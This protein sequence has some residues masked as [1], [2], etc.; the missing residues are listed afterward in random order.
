MNHPWTPL[1]PGDEIAVVAP[2]MAFD[3]TQ[4]RAAEKIVEAWGYKLKYP[5][6]ILGKATISSNSREQREK[7]LKEAL[8]SD[9]KMIWAARGGFGSLHLVPFLMKFRPQVPKL[10]MG[11]SDIVTLHQIANQRWNWATIH[12]PHVDRLAALNSTRLSELRKIISGS[13]VELSYKLK[14]MNSAAQKSQVIYSRV[15]G[16]NM[17]TLQ[18]TVGSDLQLK[19]SQRL[20]FF[21]EIGER[22]YKIDRMLHHFDHLGFFRKAEGVIFGPMVGGKEPDG[23]DR[24]DKVL[25]DFA[26]AQK[27]PVFKGLYSGHVPNSLSLPLNTA[28]E[29]SVSSGKATLRVAT[30]AQS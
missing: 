1:K 21:E 16:G 4:F 13:K 30:G 7:F 14:P 2:G 18:S 25:K 27:I 15:V 8:Q 3:W 26:L 17:V 29:L 22:G 11:F 23:S 19:T 5:K 6:N 28:A 24:T 10:L 9:A 20:L 12:G